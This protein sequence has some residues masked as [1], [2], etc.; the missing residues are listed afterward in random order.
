VKDQ[1]TIFWFRRDLRLEDNIGLYY[2]LKESE[3][4]LPIF[5]FDRNITDELK[6]NDPRITFIYDQ[7]QIIDSSLKVFGSS[8]KILFGNP[9][10]EILKLFE[11]FDI[12]AIYTNRDYEPYARKRDFL[13]KSILQTKGVEFYTYKDQVIFE[14]DEIL[15]NDG[16]PYTVFSHYKKKWLEKVRNEKIEPLNHINFNRFYK[17][18]EHFPY[19]QEFGFKSSLF[20]VKDFNF[21]N[22]ED[23]DLL[24]D[25]PS[26]DST[27]NLS[28][29]LRF[30]TISIRQ[31]ILV[32]FKL[33]ATFLSELIWREFFIQIL[34]HFP[35]V[36]NENFKKKYDGIEWLNREEDF[37]KWKNGETGYVMVDA[38]MRQL[39]TTGYM[40]NRVRMIVAGFL[41]KHLL[42][43]WRLGESYF[44]EKL[45]DY[46]LAANN[47]NWQW[48]AGTGCDSAPYFRI[49]NP[50]TQ[51]KKFDPEYAYVRK[52]IL[53]LEGFG[54]PEPMID[55]KFARERALEIYKKGL[56][57]YR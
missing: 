20:Q 16:K 24:R 1:V 51:Q 31:V 26:S 12:S 9:S 36:V 46:D 57:S 45:L 19:L 15:K 8:L 7:L 50:I 56:A 30:G 53:D 48:S 38:G 4:V 13:V 39:N 5:I 22:L 23:Y 10:E 54:Y 40:H 33:N 6:H 25:I 14:K 35:H 47:G 42:I 43:D 18:L 21:S 41:C 55:H 29:H 3:N 2:A 28:P 27:S 49:F 37:E 34:Y 11:E 32:G 44:A 17:F 52:W